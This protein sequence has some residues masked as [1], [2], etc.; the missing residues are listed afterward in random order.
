MPT[1]R[2]TNESLYKRLNYSPEKD[3]AP[4]TLVGTQANIL[5]VNPEV[6]ARSLKELI[7]LAQA[8]PGKI[9]FASSG[10]G[11]AA[12]LAG[13]AAR[14]GNDGYCTVGCAARDTNCG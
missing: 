6:P 13:E 9:N 10:Y 2:L 5:V 11:A 8:R 14:T 4:I 3:F 1:A 12:H 7:A